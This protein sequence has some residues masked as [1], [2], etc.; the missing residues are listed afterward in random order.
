MGCGKLLVVTF[1]LCAAGV[2]FG[3]VLGFVLF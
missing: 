2:A 3:Y 1:V